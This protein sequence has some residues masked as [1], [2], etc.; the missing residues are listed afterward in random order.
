MFCNWTRAKPALDCNCRCCRWNFRG[1]QI[2]LEFRPRGRI[3]VPGLESQLLLLL[4]LLLLRSRGRAG[5]LAVQER[6]GVQLGEMPGELT[7]FFLSG[8][9]NVT[10]QKNA[11][12]RELELAALLR[13]K[14]DLVGRN[15]RK[16]LGEKTVPVWNAHGKVEGHY[17]NYVIYDSTNDVEKLAGIHGNA[18]P[19]PG[20]TR[21]RGC[22][23]DAQVQVQ[24]IG[25]RVDSRQRRHRQLAERDRETLLHAIWL[26]DHHLPCPLLLNPLP[27]AVSELSGVA[28]PLSSHDETTKLCRIAPLLAAYVSPRPSSCVLSFPVFVPFAGSTITQILVNISSCFLLHKSLHN[29]IFPL[30]K[31]PC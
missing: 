28:R 30:S 5:F 19:L 7:N 18:T 16:I 10:R 13:R 8:P 20:K 1:V 14:G 27:S 4:L 24:A 23:D 21:H 17:C 22:A 3:W 11:S 6:A 2:R 12:T 29:K 15:P 9:L 26:L 25:T 31:S